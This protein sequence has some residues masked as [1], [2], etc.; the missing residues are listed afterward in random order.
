MGIVVSLRTLGGWEDLRDSTLYYV[1]LIEKA[2]KGFEGG[3][4]K[5]L[6]PEDR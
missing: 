6:Q 4:E 2:V 5:G 1:T 3:M